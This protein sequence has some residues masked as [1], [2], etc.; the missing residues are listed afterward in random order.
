[1]TFC[2]KSKVKVMTFDFLMTFDFMTLVMPTPGGKHFNCIKFN[3][4]QNI[5]AYKI[6]SFFLGSV[7]HYAY[8]IRR[9]IIFSKG[10]ADSCL[11]QQKEQN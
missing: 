10:Y 4:L 8:W 2:E 7:A 1:M 6:L 11:F 3:A 5:T 9:V